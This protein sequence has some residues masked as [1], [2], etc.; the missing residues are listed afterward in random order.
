LEAAH[1]KPLSFHSRNDMIASIFN[2]SCFSIDCLMVLIRDAIIIYGGR[3]V[4]KRESKRN[5]YNQFDENTMY[6]L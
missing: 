1:R 3:I 2:P 6:S 5:Q 4:K